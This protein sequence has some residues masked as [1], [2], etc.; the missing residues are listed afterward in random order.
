MA[1][2]FLQA[3]Y[4]PSTDILLRQY[5]LWSISDDFLMHYYA[6]DVGKVTRQLYNAATC[7]S[8]QYFPVYSKIEFGDLGL[9]RGARTPA[10]MPFTSRL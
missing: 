3:M 10:S 9:I 1:G 2:L 4:P 7:S 6:M 8:F 5:V